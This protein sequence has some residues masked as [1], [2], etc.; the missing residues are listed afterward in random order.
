MGDSILIV[1]DER[2]VLQ[3]LQRLLR[4]DGYDIHLAE[5][6][7]EAMGILSETEIAAML[8]DQ[9]MPGMSGAEVLAEAYKL[10]PDTVRIT[11]TGYT[12]L[13]SAQESINSGHVSQF[14][15][16]PWDDDHLRSV[17]ADAVKAHR[18]VHDN[19]R[20]EALA[21]QQKEELEQW[22]TQLEE[23]VQART[24]EL[25]TQNEN[26]KDLQARVEQSLRDTVGL[27]AA[28]LESHN[29]N[30]GIHC[31]RVAQLARQLALQLALSEQEVRDIEF[32]AHLHDIGK[33]ARSP[34]SKGYSQ[35]QPQTSHRHPEA[36]YAI[37][38]KV[39]GFENIALAVRHQHERYD[40]TGT[41][42]GMSGDRIPLAA[43]IIAV[44]NAYDKAV[45]PSP[46]VAE[47][48]PAKGETTVT[49]G[50]GINFDPRLVQLLLDCVEQMGAALGGEAEVELSP[51]RLKEGMLLSR[52]ILNS[53]GQL[54]L[55][56]KTLLTEEII[57][58]IRAMSDVNPLLAGVFVRC[59]AEEQTIQ[60]NSSVNTTPTPAAVA[61]TPPHRTKQS[62]EEQ[63]EKSDALIIRPAS[64][65]STQPTQPQDS[66]KTTGSSPPR[67]DSSAS[68]SRGEKPEGNGAT[69]PES[70]EESAPNPAPEPVNTPAQT[71]RKILV[72]DDSTQIGNALKRELRPANIETVSTD[73]GWT[74]LN[75][76]EQARFDAVLVDLMMPA[77]SGEELIGR[78][79]ECAPTLPCII[80]TGNATKDRVVAL[81]KEP[82]VV[83]ILT[84]PWD[85]ERLTSAIAAAVAKRERKPA[86]EIA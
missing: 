64:A 14:L 71:R 59:E 78:L 83:G 40:G 19:R 57:H 33:I 18:L 54:L 74:A 82:N 45:H 34:D 84:K 77:M 6:G 25:Q 65:S 52:P 17:V 11:L 55:K 32:A 20:L 4:R 8:C 28:T 50:T 66:G 21:R 69:S 35:R 22:N 60:E 48:L 36:G 75:L 3:S 58:R 81:S 29:P 2:H 43:R 41:P 16:K 51:K 15:L 70:P 86:A 9:R 47:F 1:D 37:L 38:S 24:T 13:A 30:L 53:N 85:H 27:L 61:G 73:S 76:I 63:T 62:S 44:V 42:N 31:K 7:Q 67:D 10:H 72:V 49:L 39:S 23:Q 80:L 56:E 12:D 79:Q 5:S 46:D 26:L 68:G